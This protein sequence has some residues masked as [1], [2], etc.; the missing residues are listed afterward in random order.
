MVNLVYL[1]RGPRERRGSSGRS[2]LRAGRGA[3]HPRGRRDAPHAACSR[4]TI[5]PIM[6]AATS[7]GI[8]IDRHRR[9]VESGRRARSRQPRTRSPGSRTRQESGVQASS[10][11]KEATSS[12]RARSRC[13][14]CTH[15]AT[16]P[17]AS[18]SWSTAASW[19]A[20]RSFSEDAGG[21]T[22]RAAMLPPCTTACQP[23]REAPRRHRRL[24]GHLYSPAG[25]ASSRRDQ[26]QEP[27]AR[28]PERRGMAGAVRRTSA[29]TAVRQ[30]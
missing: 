5:T 8:R 12:G 28:A 22:S 23:A 15:R 29:V 2:R 17:G 27:R 16:P 24:P 4:P 9:A 26:A 21:P 20:T 30:L 19:P 6:S 11:T 14:S 3:R 18:A 13:A 10:P 7:S 25:S 1:D